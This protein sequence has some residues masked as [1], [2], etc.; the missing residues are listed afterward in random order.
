LIGLEPL[1]VWALPGRW[2]ILASLAGFYWL[3]V[4]AVCSWGQAAPN[5][6]WL[7]PLQPEL[8]ALADSQR[9]LGL[10]VT[11][12]LLIGAPILILRGWWGG[13]DASKQTLG[14]AV[15]LLLL[16]AGW[17]LRTARP[18]QSR[19]GWLLTILTFIVALPVLQI[20]A[21]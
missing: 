4:M 10:L 21:V 11:L 2:L 16:A 3:T 7:K 20:I 17:W 1:W 19:T 6:P 9:W 15:F 18:Q 12:S 13:G 5:N 8:I 14:L